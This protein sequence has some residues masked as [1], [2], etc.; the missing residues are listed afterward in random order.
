MKERSSARVVL[1]VF[2]I[3]LGSWVVLAAVANLKANAKEAPQTEA[4]LWLSWSAESKSAYVW[5]VIAQ[6]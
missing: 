1:L 3:V 6:T 4:E 2:A 5:G